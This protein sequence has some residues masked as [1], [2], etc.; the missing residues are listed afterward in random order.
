MAPPSD[1][2]RASIGAILKQERT[3]QGLDIAEIEQRTKIRG[4][5]LRA[6]EDEDWEVLPGLAYV[7]GFLRTYAAALGLDADVLVDDYRADYEAPGAEPYG[8]AEGVLSERRPLDARES[9]RLDPRVIVGLAVAAIAVVLLVLGLTGG[10]DDGGD[11]GTDAPG[12]AVE[13][14]G[15]GG[16]EEKGGDED[17]PTLPERVELELV[18]RS[19]S[20]VCLVN[21]AGDV[22][23]DNA[24]MS[25][26]DKE[27]FE[28][29][30]F[31]L[32]LGFGIVEATVNGDGERLEAGTDAPV[33]YEITPRGVRQ[34][35]ADTTPECP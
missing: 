21:R 23:L 12:K 3:R 17:K 26:G 20:E 34:P 22:V 31:E 5:Y 24:L 11:T 35:T 29:D 13:R 4:K 15:R 7:R 19:D 25:A 33:I 8:I 32:G 16:G 27:A 9:R 2:P 10:S 30:E 28:A 18:A 1:D 6:L 14:N